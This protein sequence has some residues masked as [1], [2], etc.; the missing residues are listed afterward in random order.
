[1][2]RIVIALIVAIGVINSNIY[3]RAESVPLGP[4]LTDNTYSENAGT[5]SQYVDVGG[6]GSVYTIAISHVKNGPVAGK[7]QKHKVRLSIFA[8]GDLNEYDPDTVGPAKWRSELG[9]TTLR[10]WVA[11]TREIAENSPFSGEKALEFNWNDPSV[12]KD[13]EVLVTPTHREYVVTLNAPELDLAPNQ[14]FWISVLAV[15]NDFELDFYGKHRPLQPGEFV[16]LQ[17]LWWC[18]NP[19]GNP[20]GLQPLENGGQKLNTVTYVSADVG[21]KLVITVVKEDGETCYRIS[22]LPK[23]LPST[24]TLQYST[25]LAPGVWHCT[26]VLDETACSVSRRALGPQR[27]YRLI[28]GNRLVCTVQEPLLTGNP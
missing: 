27:F 8:N 10:I 23:V 17:K 12:V 28:D 21:P 1:M 15:R 22:W 2:K 6:G 9:K 20:C 18:G 13:R 7:T 25:A 11:R 3:G 24:Y 4:D 14:D 16:D 5:R 19:P 26:D